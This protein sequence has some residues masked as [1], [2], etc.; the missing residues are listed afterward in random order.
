MRAAVLSGLL[1]ALCWAVGSQEV[2]RSNSLGMR[3][4]LVTD[5]E[6]HPYV[7]EVSRRGDIEQ[8]VLYQDGRP[9]LRTVRD[10]AGGVVR[11][12]REVRDGVLAAERVYDEKGRLLEESDDGRTTSYRYSGG[13]LVEARVQD[14]TGPVHREVYSYTSGGRLRQAV[15][16]LTDGSAVVLAYGF[17]ERRL[18]E[19]IVDSADTVTVS[20]YN[21]RGRIV[22]REVR[23]AGRLAAVS[24]YRY[25]DNAL[26]AAEDRD[27]AAGV[28][29]VRTYDGAGRLTSEERS[30]VDSTQ[31]RYS[32]DSE[33][34]KSRVVAAGLRGLE[35]WRYEYDAGGELLRETYLSRGAVRRVRTHTGERAWQDELYRTGTPFLRVIY[36]ADVRV[37][38]ELIR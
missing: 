26:V 14:S 28:T 15:R 6:A 8:S 2:Y 24:S 4:G 22:S 35:E 17:S 12:E 27:L 1:L 29:S 34:R 23:I 20:R 7:L 13:V 5:R 3:L 37:R 9:V 36:E 25:D 16:T 18:A 11:R 19:E 33:G 31:T 21:E 10:L 30:G 32:Y 38:E